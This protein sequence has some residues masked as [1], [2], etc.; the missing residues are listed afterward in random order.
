MLVN[1]YESKRKY[2][3]DG[4]TKSYDF[5]ITQLKKLKS[6]IKNNEDNL[7]NAFYLDLGKPQF[8]AYT[9]EIGIVYEQIK[10]TINNLKK[11]MKPRK[12]NTPIYLQPSS[13][14]IYPEP[15]GVV[16]IISPWNYPFQLTISPL[17]G[18]IAAGNCAV[19]KPSNK[20]KNT[21]NVISKIIGEAFSPEYISVVEGPGDAT[22]NPLIENNRFDHI[23]FTGSVSVGR[24][25]LELSA[26]HLTT[27]TLELGGK[28]PTIVHSDADIDTTAKRITWAKFFNVGQTCIAPDYILVHESK[29]EAL[30]DNIKFY[31][32]KY[33]GNNTEDSNDYGRIISNNHFDR[34][35]SL[36]EGANILVG[37]NHN[38]DKRF[39]EPTLVDGVTLESPVMKEEIFGPILPILTY[40]DITEVVPI[41]RKNRY[42]LSL[43]LFTE[44]KI[45]EN[46]II[47]NIEFGGGCINHGISHVVNPNLPFGGVGY[48]GM[49]AYHSKYTFDAFTHEKSIF[50]QSGIFEVDLKYP[51]YNKN[52]LK[53][54]K[55]FL[56]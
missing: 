10:S 37:G 44:D 1:S 36:L 47:G 49:G 55:R 17:I 39:I 8:E 31:I 45:I 16:L 26:K 28:S 9:S 32:K 50:K 48:S 29:K 51:P 6:A 4:K 22:V 40:Q 2:F 54:V 41:I 5:R 27:V 25:I 21:Q 43:Y 11:W 20:S 34:L 19:I 42:P 13:S 18:A 3:D 38:R 53:L 30:I 56:K 7:M 35:V 14:Y 23:F 12:V 46:Y 33:Y 52:K 24:K 15:K